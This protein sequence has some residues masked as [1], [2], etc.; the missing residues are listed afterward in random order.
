MG[1]VGPARSPSDVPLPSRGELDQCCA[2]CPG[3]LCCVVL[4]RMQ[5]AVRLTTKVKSDSSQGRR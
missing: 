5:T 2:V 4:Q 1:R 3:S